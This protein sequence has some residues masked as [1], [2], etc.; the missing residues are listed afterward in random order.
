[1]FISAALAVGALALYLPHLDKA[2]YYLDVDEVLSALNAQ[3]L[4]IRGRDFHGRFMPL[5]LQSFAGA[6]W[7]PPFLTYSIAFWLR[8]LPF[9]EFSVR[10]PMVLGAAVNIVLSFWIARILFGRIFLG[11]VAAILLAL[12]PSHF[13]MARLAMDNQAPL[14]FVLGWLLCVVLF[15]RNDDTRLL[16]AAG[17]CL[18]AGMFSYVGAIPL[19]PIYLALTFLVLAVRRDRWTRFAAAVAGFIVP[20]SVAVYWLTGHPSVVRLWFMHYHNEAVASPGGVNALRMAARFYQLDQVADLYRRFWSPRFL[21]TDGSSI[22][23]FST[24]HA[25]VFL[26]PVAG[27]LAVCLIR[28]I[29]R[30]IPAP[31][32]ALLLGGFLAAPIPASLV[33]ID[34]AANG[35]AIWRAAAVEP[36]GVLLATYGFDYLWTAATER[37]RR[38]MWL[39]AGIV[40]LGLLAVYSSFLPS[41]QTMMSLAALSIMAAVVMLLIRGR[42]TRSIGVLVLVGLGTLGVVQFV[43]FYLDYFTAYRARYAVDYAHNERDVIERVIEEAHSSWPPAIY[44]GFR[45]DAAPQYWRFYLAKHGRLDLQAR[46]QIENTNVGFDANSFQSLPKGGLVVTPIGWGDA[47]SVIDRMIKERELRV[48]DIVREIDGRPIYWILEIDR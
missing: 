16:F 20:F 40:P 8:L 34:A 25:G 13:I 45:F 39:T 10:L 27:L 36:F 4:S 6:F 17:G 28:A 35:H 3:S 2:P 37:E 32:L 23:L 15:L 22:L 31:H 33:G 47:D 21:F 42:S 26:L 46:T 5:F 18:G 7:Y 29:R 12:T 9:S 38:I 1:V 43:D 44:L 30:R 19:M 11:C 14:P 41:A 24:R 48:H